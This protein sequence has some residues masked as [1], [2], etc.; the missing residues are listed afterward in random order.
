M[1]SNPPLMS[2]YKKLLSSPLNP[3]NDL[4]VCSG[5][6][7]QLPVID[8]ELL[9]TENAEFCKTDIAAAAADWG[10]FQVVNHGIPSDLLDRIQSEQVKLFQQPFDK[11]SL[12]FSANSYRWGSP[13]ATSVHQLSWSEA[14]HIPLNQSHLPFKQIARETIEELAALLSRLASLLAGILAERLGRNAAY[15]EEK[16]TNETCY[17][18]LNHY[19]QCPIPSNLFGLVPHTDSD[20]LTILVQDQVGGLE[21]MK[22][23][24]WIPV[25]PNPDALVVNIGDLFQAWSNGVY[26]SVEH[27]VVSSPHHERYSVAFFLCPSYD[28]IIQSQETETPIYRRFSFREYRQQVQED[29]KLIGHKVGLAR[30]LA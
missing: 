2:T 30:F 23:G 6:E 17:M 28:T 22:F 7:C 19:P 24:K 26:K 3:C 4:G 16:C 21:L 1:D 25:K 15:L 11:K 18:R 10:F 9:N 13:A 20:F 12:E 14:Y 27:R 8:L 5:E 29:V